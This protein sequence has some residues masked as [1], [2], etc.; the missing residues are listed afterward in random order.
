MG[1]VRFLGDGPPLIP[2]V[3]VT[4]TLAGLAVYSW[5]GQVAA[6]VATGIAM[7]AL[8]FCGTF[9]MTLRWTR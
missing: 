3:L 2:C 5:R 1:D 4:G 9:F 7:T 6:A 8:T